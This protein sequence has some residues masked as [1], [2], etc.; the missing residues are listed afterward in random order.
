MAG[1]LIAASPVEIQTLADE[2]GLD[3]AARTA[4][5]HLFHALTSELELDA[6]EI[7]PTDGEAWPRHRFYFGVTSGPIRQLLEALEAM[8][9]VVDASDRP[10]ETDGTPQTLFVEG[11]DGGY[12]G[13]LIAG[14]DA[15]WLSRVAVPAE[16]AAAA[17]DPIG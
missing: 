16:K 15:E 17:S 8:P 13:V 9:E 2:A 11:Q 12:T 6:I 14:H 4:A 1:L 3:A 7:H 5:L 10:E